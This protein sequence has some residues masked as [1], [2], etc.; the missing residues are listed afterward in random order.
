MGD[1]CSTCAERENERKFLT[2]T[3]LSNVACGSVAW[4]FFHT[5]FVLKIKHYGS[6][7][8]LI[9]VSLYCLFQT[10]VAT[11]LKCHAI[12]AEM[13]EALSLTSVSPTLQTLIESLVSYLTQN[14]RH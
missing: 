9:M 4:I 1:Q 6:V 11:I 5:C 7:C 3:Q 2:I 13:L 10:D 14:Y 12:V 8:K